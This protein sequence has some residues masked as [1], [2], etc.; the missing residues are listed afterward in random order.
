MSTSN[1]AAEYAD[2]LAIA[3][4]SMCNPSWHSSATR[5][6]IGL[7]EAMTMPGG[8]ADTHG[9]APVARDA[10][11]VHETLAADSDVTCF[12]DTPNATQDRHMRGLIERDMMARA[13]IRHPLVDNESLC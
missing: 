10:R 11:N 6:D 7:E 5:Y 2:S 4:S 1:E 9:A 13:V 8:S 12:N 3:A